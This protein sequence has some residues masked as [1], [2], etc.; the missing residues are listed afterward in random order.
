MSGDIKRPGRRLKLIALSTA[1]TLVPGHAYCQSAAPPPPFRPNIDQRSV[2][3]TTGQLIAG[4]VDI[5]IGP[6]DHRGL[7]FVRQWTPNQ[8]RQAIVPTI[9]GSSNYPLVTYN[10]QSYRFEW[11]S[12]YTGYIPSTQDGSSLST[13]LSKFTLSDGTVINFGLEGIPLQYY[14]SLDN[15]GLG[16]SIVYPDGT[17]TQFHYKLGQYVP[18]QG[19]GGYTVARLSSVTSSIGYQLKVE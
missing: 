9:S 4:A 10:G 18:C 5:S 2:S 7:K 19:C 12:S 16:E 17:K 15:M 6:D 1:C 13:D 8:W 3:L 14:S 11:N